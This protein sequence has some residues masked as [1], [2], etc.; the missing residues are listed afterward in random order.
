MGALHEI[1][2]M[3]SEEKNKTKENLNSLKR[4]PS[5]KSKKSSDNTDQQLKLEQGDT[6]NMATYIEQNKNKTL[7]NI[8]SINMTHHQE[9]NKFNETVPIKIAS[10]FENLV[11]EPENT[12]DAIKAPAKLKL[13]EESKHKSNNLNLASY[14]LSVPDDEEIECLKEDSVLKDIKMSHVTPITQNKESSKSQAIANQSSEEMRHEITGHTKV[15]KDDSKT[16]NVSVQI[17]NSLVTGINVT[18]AVQTSQKVEKKEKDKT[19]LIASLPMEDTSDA[20][21]NDDA[22]TI[23]SDSDDERTNST[24]KTSPSELALEEIKPQ[25]TGLPME[26]TS[27]AW[28]NDDVGTIDSDS[29]DEIRDVESD[30]KK[31]KPEKK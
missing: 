27:D 29:D 13:A 20:W 22:G 24:E 1:K 9:K 14:S 31:N 25:I 3:D 7:Q 18:E 23:D 19:S 5:K 15:T 2:L 16:L 10:S 26:D 28:M 21:M 30:N 6:E 17:E 4:R 12:S 11:A 8:E